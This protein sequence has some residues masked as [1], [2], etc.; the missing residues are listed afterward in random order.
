MEAARLCAAAIGG[1][2]LVADLVRVLARGRG[3][4]SFTS[5]GERELKGLPEPVPVAVVGWEPPELAQATLPFPPGLATQAPLPFSGRSEQLTAL[6]ETWKHASAG[7]RHAVLVSGE[8]GIGKTRLTAEVARHVH[9]GG[10]IVLFGRCDEDLGVAFQPFVEALVEF[11][12]STPDLAVL[13]RYAGELARL[14]PSLPQQFPALDPPLASDPETER[15]RLFD[16]VAALLAALST[17]APVL[18]VLDDLH[19]AEK[20]TLLSAPSCPALSRIHARAHRRDL[21][22]HRPRSQPSAG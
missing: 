1:Q 16:A 8:A 11:L 20:P 19:W 2:I 9:D 7:E 5:S 22:R 12:R 21:P 17:Q 14:V 6:L 10:G 4:H 3:G 18:L 13:G 15:Y